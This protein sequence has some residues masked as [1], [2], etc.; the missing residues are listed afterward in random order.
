MCSSPFL[1]EEKPKVIKVFRNF[2]FLPLE[3]VLNLGLF[4][5]MTKYNSLNEFLDEN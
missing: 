4:K 3:D 2:L 5:T 1:D